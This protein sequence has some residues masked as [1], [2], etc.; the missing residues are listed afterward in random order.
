MRNTTLLFLVKKEERDDDEYEPITDICLAMK[1]RGFGVGRYNGVGG[2]VEEG[3]T[4]EDAV[5][6]EAQEEIGVLVGSIEKCAELTFVFPH[7]PSFDQL[8][9]VYLT[10]EWL[11]EPEESDEMNPSWFTADAIPYTDMW[12]DDIFWLPQVLKGESV[13]G[14]FVFGEGDVIKEQEVGT[15]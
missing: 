4:I 1:K 6:R 8:V 7:Q 15:L 9:H 11:G 12:P 13:K 10:D 2:K 5:K 3:E 14:R